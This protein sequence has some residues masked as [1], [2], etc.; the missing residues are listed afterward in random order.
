M[1]FLNKAE[2]L[3]LA[4]EL[5]IENAEELPWKDLQ[6]AIA[7]KQ[8]QLEDEFND[9]YNI[10]YNGYTV[11]PASASSDEIVF[12]KEK[13]ENENTKKLKEFLRTHQD[14]SPVNMN[15]DPMSAYY[16]KS[17]MVAPELPPER[18]RLVKYDEEL[19][20]E[21][22]LEERQ[23]DMDQNDHVFDKSGGEV[24]FSNRAG[25]T[26][27]AYMDYTTGTYRI[28]GK[29]ERKV[30]AMSSVPKENYGLGIT[31]GVD[32]FPVVT[33]QGRSGYLWTHPHFSNVKNE[34][35]NSGYYHEYK[36]QFKRE[37]NIWYV[38]GKTLACDIGLVNH[39]FAEI[40]EKERRKN[41]EQNAY[42]RSLGL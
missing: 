1:A 32:L 25:K 14:F 8:K 37:P 27:E 13:Q 17:V 19:G 28:K 3:A 15:N 7:V 31:A 35:M 23:F 4:K 11:D 12:V 40:E 30:V 24:D 39:I 41:E 22:E 33:W 21:M 38:A 5:G 34:L 6:S 10:T 20:N 29:N 9:E 36:D 18:Y 16:G 42:R 2:S 26:A